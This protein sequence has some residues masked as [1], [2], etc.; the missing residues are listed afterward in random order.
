MYAPFRGVSRLSAS[1]ENHSVGL[2]WEE[3][4][5]DFFFPSVFGLAAFALGFVHIKLKSS[6]WISEN[7]F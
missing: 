7:S 1:V 2:P 3:Y 6:W 5:C 4:V